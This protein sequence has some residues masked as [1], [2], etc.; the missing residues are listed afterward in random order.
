[1]ARRALA[2]TSLAGVPESAVLRVGTMMFPTSRLATLA[3]FD[4]SESPVVPAHHAVFAGTALTFDVTTGCAQQG[5]GRFLRRLSDEHGHIE[6]ALKAVGASASRVNVVRGQAWDG[7]MHALYWSLDQPLHTVDADERE[8]EVYLRFLAN[9]VIELIRQTFR[10]GQLPH[11]E[12]AAAAVP[13][14]LA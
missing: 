14:R 12:A 10:R 5:A 8:S 3:T 11:L 6:G 13:S 9:N 4:R 7:R 1:M 2:I